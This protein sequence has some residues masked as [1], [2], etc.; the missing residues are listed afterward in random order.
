MYTAKNE[1][2][3]DKAMHTYYEYPKFKFLNKSR[4]SE[5]LKIPAS[6]VAYDMAKFLTILNP[7]YG[8]WDGTCPVAQ[9]NQK[10]QTAQCHVKSSVPF[11]VLTKKDT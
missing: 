10:F 7:V 2:E 11:N 9:K 5:R 1:V 4:L 8:I 6:N 3:I